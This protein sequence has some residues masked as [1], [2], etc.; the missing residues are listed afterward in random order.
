MKIFNLESKKKILFSDLSNEIQNTIKDIPIITDK[1]WN[2]TRDYYYL[3]Y[4]ENEDI[5][6]PNGRRHEYEFDYDF[7]LLEEKLINAKILRKITV[8]SCE[9]VGLCYLL[10]KI[11]INQ[12]SF[13]IFREDETNGTGENIEDIVIIEF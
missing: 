9:N 10:E 12:P 5:I 1:I 13:A 4:P 8:T 11:D 7:M 2:P 6:I 3:K